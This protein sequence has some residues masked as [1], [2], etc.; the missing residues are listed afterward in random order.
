MQLR[1]IAVGRA[2]VD[3]FAPSIA[4]L[5]VAVNQTITKKSESSTAVRGVRFGDCGSP[6]STIGVA[7]LQ[8]LSA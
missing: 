8:S 4:R 6:F 7:W 2:P 1:F 3:F 5:R